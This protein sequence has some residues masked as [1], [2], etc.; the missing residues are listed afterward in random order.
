MLHDIFRSF[1]HSYTQILEYRPKMTLTASLDIL[2]NH[3]KE[4]RKSR[5]ETKIHAYKPSD[6][7]ELN[8]AQWFLS[9]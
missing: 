2:P 6:Y 5:E 3:H 8:R 4:F 1:P 7:W 9:S